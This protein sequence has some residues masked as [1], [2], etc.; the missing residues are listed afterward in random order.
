LKTWGRRRSNGRRFPDG[1]GL[2]SGALEV[3]LDLGLEIF[4]ARTEDCLRPVPDGDHAGRTQRLE[5]IWTGFGDIRQFHAEARD[6]RIQADDVRAAAEGPDQLQLDAH[7][8]STARDRPV[9]SHVTRA[10]GAEPFLG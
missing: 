8:A 7:A 4:A 1:V 9:V 3:I 6:T 2:R 10:S 5:R